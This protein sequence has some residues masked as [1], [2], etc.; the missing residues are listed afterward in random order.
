MSKRV[1]IYTRYSSVMQRTESCEDQ[2]RKVKEGLDRLGIDHRH[3][4]VVRD[5]AESG[6]TCRRTEDFARAQDCDS[7]ALMSG[8]GNGS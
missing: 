6:T 2:E 8:H 7:V 3:A 5:E 1:A 4:V